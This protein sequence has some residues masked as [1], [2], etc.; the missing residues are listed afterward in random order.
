MN[1]NPKLKKN[2]GEGTFIGNAIRALA[3][4]GKVISPI[5]LDLASNVNGL[6]GLSKLADAIRGDDNIDTSDKTYLLAELRADVEQEKERTKRWEL[7]MNSDSWMSKNARPIA[8]YNML[9]MFDLVII[10]ALFNRE[11]RNEIVALAIPDIYIT[12]F[13]SAFLTVL[14]G[15]FILRTVEKRNKNKY[16]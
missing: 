9:L 1:E 12:L 10:A 7:D 11:L 15:Y 16:N 5:I 4:S 13:T 14:N 2:G 8:L 6:G 3:S